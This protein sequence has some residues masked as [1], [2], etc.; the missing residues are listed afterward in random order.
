[1]RGPMMTA[2][3]LPRPGERPALD[4]D[5]HLVDGELPADLPVIPGHDMGGRSAL[6]GAAVLIP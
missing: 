1:M 2:M 5:L 3:R 6:E 4:T